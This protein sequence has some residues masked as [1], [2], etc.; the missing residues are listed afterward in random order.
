MLIIV[1][2]GVGIILPRQQK[3][4]AINL[5]NRVWENVLGR[6]GSVCIYVVSK[7]LSVLCSMCVYF[8]FLYLPL[9]QCVCVL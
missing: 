3:Y 9:S 2:T 4:R 8:V 1:R 6:G 7:R 5:L